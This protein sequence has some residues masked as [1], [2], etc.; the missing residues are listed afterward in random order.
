M[1][2]SS[3]EG[4]I[5][6]G[7]VALELIDVA[8]LKLENSMDVLLF[9]PGE[10]PIFITI[11]TISEPYHFIFGDNHF[12]NGIFGFVMDGKKLGYELNMSIGV[13]ILFENIHG[14]VL[15][16]HA[17]ASLNIEEVEEIVAENG[18]DSYL[19]GRVFK[20]RPSFEGEVVNREELISETDK[21][22]FA[23]ELNS[24]LPERKEH[25]SVK[26]FEELSLAVSRIVWST[27]GRFVVSFS[28]KYDWN[29]IEKGINTKEEL[30]L[31]AEHIIEEF[32]KIIKQVQASIVEGKRE[33]HDA[34]HSLSELNALIEPIRK[35]LV[36]VLN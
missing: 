24:F 14:P 21:Y 36:N 31:I 4:I 34:I 10:R 2:H 13:N 15:Y 25:Y 12:T 17:H 8:D 18:F 7:R 11:P 29:P 30:T 23:V 26:G 28:H 5:R 1:F 35:E 20:E 33:K 27:Y 9:E 19:D 16:A 22:S 32:E 6:N 3:Q